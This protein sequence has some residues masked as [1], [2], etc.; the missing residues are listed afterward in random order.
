[1]YF[2]YKITISFQMLLSVYTQWTN[3][4]KLVN[5]KGLFSCKGVKEEM[6]GNNFLFNKQNGH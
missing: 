4:R 6:L 3:E 1:M 5:F 2:V